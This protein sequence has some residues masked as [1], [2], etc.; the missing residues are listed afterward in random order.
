MYLLMYWSYAE[1]SWGRNGDQTSSG[2]DNPEGKGLDAEA[3]RGPTA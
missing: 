2:S 1:Q 3:Q